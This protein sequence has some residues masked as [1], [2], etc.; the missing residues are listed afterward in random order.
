[1]QIGKCFDYVPKLQ[2]CDPKNIKALCKSS[3]IPPWWEVRSTS[4]CNLRCHTTTVYFLVEIDRESVLP[5]IFR[6]LCDVWSTLKSAAFVTDEC[7]VSSLGSPERLK[8][9]VTV[10][11]RCV[12]FDGACTLICIPGPVYLHMSRR[13]CMSKMRS[14]VSQDSGNHGRRLSSNDCPYHYW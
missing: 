1:M 5:P 14:C 3:K 4:A 11:T 6:G 12:F 8:K 9:L 7:N 13:T 10:Q 2:N